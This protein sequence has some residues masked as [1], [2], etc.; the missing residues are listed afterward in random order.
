MKT[1]ILDIE[2]YKELI[3]YC[4]YDF[5]SDEC[6]IFEV[7]KNKNELKDIYDFIKNQQ[8]RIITFNGIHFDSVIT[9][10]IV[11]EYNKLSKLSVL[12]FCSEIYRASQVIINSDNNQNEFYKYKYHKLYEE[13]DVFLLVSKGLRISK[14]L[15]LKFYA[16]NLDMDIMEMPVY[17]GKVGLTDTDINLV[18]KYVRQDVNVTKELALKKREEINLR[19]WI[20]KEYGL[21][22]LSWDAPKIASELLLDSFCKKT[23]PKNISLYDYKKLIRN[24]K[25]EKPS[26]IRLGDFIPNIQFKNKQFQDLYNEICNSY[27]TFSKEI[28]VRNYDGSN[29]KL[30]YSVGGLHSVN[31]NE[32]YVTKGNTEIIDID[33]QSMYPNLIKNL[34]SFNNDFGT[35][36]LELYSDIIDQRV[37]AKK[38][39]EKVKDT[40]FKLILNATSGILDN[41]YSWIYSPEQILAL[42]IT[43]QLYITKL[44]EECINNNIKIVSV[45]TDG[46]TLE[47]NS[48]DKRKLIDIVTDVESEIN[49]LFEYTFYKFINYKSV[50]DYIALT[51][52]DKI[53]I[54][55]EYVYEKQ[56]EGS[57]EFLIIPIALKEFYVNG[58]PIENTIKNHNNIFDF[59]MGK[60]IDKQYSVYYNGN[61]I[62]QLNR[63]Y[64][65]KKGAYL[66]KQKTGKSTMENVL[67]DTPVCIYNTP[68]NK[69]PQE[70]QVDFSYYIKKANEKL[71]ELNNNNQMSLF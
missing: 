71:M 28:I 44:I 54:K 57:N 19:F 51:D 32:K 49:L 40:F 25:Y 24:R 65:S 56:L 62:Q 1:Y 53:K 17:H 41:Q 22:C 67:K 70:L 63:I 47:L 5:Y 52:D 60:K 38:N 50:N 4:F 66:Y 55:G 7:S 6:I 9:N 27:N 30:Q 3:L 68:D 31:C 21:D 29:I 48:N 35:H 13:I 43:G 14:K 58:I 23:L 11:T 26:Q 45:N 36:L 15:S 12:D 69:T 16:Y 8:L 37:L 34:K 64:V 46:I 61:K 2:T 42:R 18:R 59:C 33:V 39:K 10:Y 20:R